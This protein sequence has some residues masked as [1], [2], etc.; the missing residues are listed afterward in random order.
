M[1]SIA[2]SELNM[3]YKYPSEN[4]N[5]VVCDHFCCLSFHSKHDIKVPPCPAVCMCL[6]LT[7]F[8]STDSYHKTYNLWDG[9]AS[10][11][12]RVQAG[13]LRESLFDSHQGQ[14]VLLKRV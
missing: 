9:I 8:E 6:L 11:M 7:Y 14:E 2:I 1:P 10:I 4:F 12:S 5:E 3:Q 13:Q